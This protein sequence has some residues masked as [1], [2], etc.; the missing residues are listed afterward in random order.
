MSQVLTRVKKV[1]ARVLSID[2]DKVVPEADII[3]DLGADSLDT[4]DLIMELEDEFNIKFPD[5]KT[6]GI[7]T[8]QDVLTY[9]EETSEE[10]DH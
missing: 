3:Q 8:I 1:V 9:I 5:G 4:V 10:S 2:A 7:Q 6:E